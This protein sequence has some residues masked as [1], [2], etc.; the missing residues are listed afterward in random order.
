M[1]PLVTRRCGRNVATAG[2]GC[3][4]RQDAGN[5]NGY[6]SADYMSGTKSSSRVNGGMAGFNGFSRMLR[7]FL[8]T[9]TFGLT[10]AAR[11]AREGATGSPDNV[12]FVPVARVRRHHASS[13]PLCRVQGH[14]VRGGVESWQNDVCQ[15]ATGN[16]L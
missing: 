7:W 9:A 3:Y 15:A 11:V 12:Y 8:L 16:I 14:W 2:H 4:R 10:A 1:N 13:K 6:Y 5:P